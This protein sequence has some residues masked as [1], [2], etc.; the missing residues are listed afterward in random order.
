M[1][2]VVS[3]A[4]GTP[5]SIETPLESI[6]PVNPGTSFTGA[7]SGLAPPTNSGTSFTGALSGLA[8]PTNS[9][10]SF[11]GAL[12]GLAP[13]TNGCPPKSSIAPE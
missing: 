1:T 12:S 2:R 6:A 8:P 9:G 5:L 7:L 10:T 11:T 4:F 13:P 3:T